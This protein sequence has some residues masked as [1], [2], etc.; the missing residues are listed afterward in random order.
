MIRKEALRQVIAQQKKEITSPQET[1]PRKVL[2]QLPEW[3]KDNRIIIITGIRRCGKST[4]LKQI[5][6]QKKGCCYLN[7]EHEQFL[8]F[9]AQDFEDL[10]ELL[11]E[12]YGPAQLYFFDEIQN[13]EKFEAF[14]RRLQDQ[15][16]KVILTGS[17]ATLLSKELGTKLTGRYKAIELYPFSFQEFLAFQKI[18]WNKDWFYSTE[19]KVQL[20]QSFGEYLSKGGF[21]EYLINNDDTYLKTIYDNILYRDIISRYALKKQKILRE[22]VQL[23]LRSVSSQVTYNSLKS[24]L[25][26]ANSITVKEYIGYLHNS[27][28]IFELQKLDFSL[29]RQLAA[30][31]KIYT[32]DSA[33]YRLNGLPFSENKGPI[34]EN[35]VF[36]ELQRQNKEI[37]YFSG[38]REC[39]FVVKEGAKASEV[40]QVCHTL[41]EQNKT[42][43]IEGLLEALEHF[44]LKTG[45]IITT[46]QEEEMS[47]ENKN[48]M[49]IPVWKWLL[50][51]S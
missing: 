33:M 6:Q 45:I 31:K 47:I 46:E 30:P 7:F 2:D 5:M 32:I 15:R 40:I 28:L 14:V 36:V 26:L 37:Y 20:L 29:R 9:Q 44:K 3:F 41:N 42:R 23:L 11:I 50:A 21:P 13:I 22:L 27:Y 17:N 35:N 43:E 1:V 48:I 4:L 38:K 49:I 12:C 16:K 8:D 51:C 18:I 19:K 10:H 24:A 34:L 25:G 39:D